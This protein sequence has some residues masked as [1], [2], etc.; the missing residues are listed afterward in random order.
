MRPREFLSVSSFHRA[1]GHIARSIFNS[2]AVRLAGGRSQH[3]AQTGVATARDAFA[4]SENKATVAPEGNTASQSQQTEPDGNSPA[5]K[6][7]AS[8]SPASP[9]ALAKSLG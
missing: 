2:R 7:F 3:A 8:S 1:P 6:A 9:A 5:K 4:G